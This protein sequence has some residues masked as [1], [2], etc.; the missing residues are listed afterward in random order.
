[1]RRRVQ[2]V[3]W[4]YPTIFGNY[5]LARALGDGV[6]SQYALT[7]PLPEHWLELIAKLEGSAE[8]G[9]RGALPAEGAT[10]AQ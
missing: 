8:A 9:R 6:R 7:E 2:N 4:S 3:M 10:A 5:S 1:M